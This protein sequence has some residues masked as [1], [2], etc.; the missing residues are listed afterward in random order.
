MPKINLAVISDLHIGYG[1]RSREFCPHEDATQVDEGY[2]SKFL[3]FVESNDIKADYL[4]V[5]GDITGKAAP[6]EFSLASET[7]ISIAKALGVS[8]EKIL[9]VPGNHDKDWSVQPQAVADETGG[10]AAQMYGALTHDQ[11]IFNGILG[12]SK[13]S[14]LS[15]ACA[16]IWDFD[17]LIVV[18]YNSSHHDDANQKPHHGL[19][20]ND[21]LLWLE[22]ELQSF[23]LG[24][25]KTK[26]FLVHHH[27]LQYS[28]HIP[29]HPDFSGM[30]N[31]ENLLTLLE[32]YK[33]D[34]V[35]HG[36][37]HIPRFTTQSTNSGH[38]IVI[39]GAGSFSYQ[40]DVSYNGHASNQF[41]IVEINGRDDENECIVGLLKNWSFL[42]GHGWM[43]SKKYLGIEQSK[44]FGTYTTPAAL[45]KRLKPRVEALFQQ[46]PYVTWMELVAEDNCLK[47]LSQD[48]VEG[49]LSKIAGDLGVKCMGEL[50]ERIL[51]AIRPKGDLS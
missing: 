5:P 44:G 1:A 37:K 28:N 14:I 27:P 40:L 26:V 3:Q 21:A 32:K 45:K 11:L 38:P 36:H 50:G 43:P 8:E 4:I 42:S 9:F 19:V 34:L 12:R 18:G 25:Q 22:K 48:V 49:V 39:L 15:D 31:A 46:R 51:L 23:D 20:S 47:Y 33:F 29:D 6:L 35:L 13:S 17:N 24:L 30:T 41:H 16:A 2:L 7:I 10:G